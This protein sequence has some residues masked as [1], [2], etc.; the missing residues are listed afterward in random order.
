MTDH[1]AMNDKHALSVART[2][3]SR[4]NAKKVPPVTVAQETP[5]PPLYPADQMYG[6]VGANLKKSF[7]IREVT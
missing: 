2:I 6:I 3:V 5:E 4:L 1:Y 7:D